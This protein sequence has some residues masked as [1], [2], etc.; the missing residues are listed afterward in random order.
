LIG[1]TNTTV[2]SSANT[3]TDLGWTATT[4]SFTLPAGSALRTASTTGGAIG[5]PRWA[6]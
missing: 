5:D 4:T 6:K 3:T 1:A 2:Q